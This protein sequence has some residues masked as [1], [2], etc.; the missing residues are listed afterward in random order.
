[1]SIMIVRVKQQHNMSVEKPSLLSEQ[2]TTHYPVCISSGEQSRTPCAQD[3]T[4]SSLFELT[5]PPPKT[6]RIS[7]QMRKKL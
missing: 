5:H 6:P 2:H 4:D 1:M 3:A 7:P